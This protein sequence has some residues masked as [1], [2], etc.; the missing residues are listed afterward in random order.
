MKTGASL[1][2][3]VDDKQWE[4]FYNMSP[5]RT[6]FSS[7][8]FLNLEGNFHKKYVLKQN[9]EIVAALIVP[10]NAQGMPKPGSFGSMHQ[11]ILFNPRVD[12]NPSKKTEIFLTLLRLA[13]ANEIK[14]DVALHPNI[15]D[16]RP[17]NWLNTELSEEKK[18]EIQVRFTGIITLN[19]FSDFEEYLNTLPK[20]R[21]DEIRKNSLRIEHCADSLLFAE[22]YKESFSKRAI[23]F[24]NDE[25]VELMKIFQFATNHPCGKLTLAFEESSSKPIAGI[26]TLEDVDTV[27]YWFAATKPGFRQKA[28]NSKLLS[29]A[30]CKAIESKKSRIDTCGMNSKEIGFFKGSFGAKPTATYQLRYS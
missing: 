11:G 19:E 4:N 9:D 13:V 22:L 27:Y 28:G 12:S 15:S 30:I 3:F 25:W 20:M 7:V 14:F 21:R 17:V 10:L 23:E 24:A 6:P 8:E 29:S 26:I 16:I 2:I 18:I 1:E 5:Q